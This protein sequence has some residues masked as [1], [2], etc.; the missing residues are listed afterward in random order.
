MVVIQF[1]YYWLFKAKERCD[2]NYAHAPTNDFYLCHATGEG[3]EVLMDCKVSAA[4]LAVHGAAEMVVIKH[5][6]NHN[7]GFIVVNSRLQ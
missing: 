1:C 7:L 2:L 6:E 3:Q 5:L 4:L